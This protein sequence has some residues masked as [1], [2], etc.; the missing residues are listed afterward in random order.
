MHSQLLEHKDPKL[1]MAKVFRMQEQQYMLVR[2]Q[3]RSRRLQLVYNRHDEAVC[4]SNVRRKP[5]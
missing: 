5:A 3:P 4:P 2:N 1:H